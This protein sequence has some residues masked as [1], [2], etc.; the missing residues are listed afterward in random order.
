MVR[1]SVVVVMERT[2][3]IEAV[4]LV[5][6][7]GPAKGFD[8]AEEGIGR[9]SVADLLTA[10]CILL[11]REF[12]ARVVES[13]ERSLVIQRSSG[14]RV[15]RGAYTEVDV[16]TEEWGRATVGVA[17]ETV[18]SRT[19]EPEEG[20]D[21]KVDEVGV[22]HTV[23]GV[24][25][26]Q[27][28]TEGSED[29]DVDRVGPRLGV[30]F[31]CEGFEESAEYGSEALFSRRSAGIPSTQVGDALAD[32]QEYLVHCRSA[33]RVVGTSL[34]AVSEGEDEQVAGPGFGVSDF[35]EGAGDSEGAAEADPV[36]K[37]AVLLGHGF[38][39][40]GM[41]GDVERS[42]EVSAE[43]ISVGRVCSCHGCG[44]G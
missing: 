41:G 28:I 15:D 5:S 11:V 19:E 3:G 4:A 44:C 42:A 30:I 43:A 31:V 16:S 37:G 12:E 34:S 26:V 23:D 2:C 38:G 1:V 32:G 22:E 9:T 29:R 40:V 27:D 13:G 20:D 10:H 35:T 8:W 7:D 21:D 14:G 6:S 25:R 36:G 17:T 39:Y 18:F 33:D 24:T